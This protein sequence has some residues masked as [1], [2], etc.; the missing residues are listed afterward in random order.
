MAF[1][2]KGDSLRSPEFHK[3]KQKEKWLKISAVSV[4][5]VLLIMTPILLSRLNRFLVSNIEI[6]GN[7]VTQPEEIE[8]LIASDLDGNY[9]LIF[10]KSNALLYPKR[11][12]LKDI[13]ENIPRIKTVDATLSGPKTLVIKVTEREPSGLYC[14]NSEVSENGCYFIDSQGFIFSRAASFTGDVYFIY[15][16][17]PPL[18]DPLGKSYLPTED[19]QKIPQFIKSLKEIGVNPHSLISTENE[20]HLILPGGG[21][22]IFNKKDKLE[23]IK[24]NLE[25]FLNDPE[26]MHAPDFLENVSYIDMRFG[27]KVFYKLKT[28]E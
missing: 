19:F 20:Y 18:E 7:S 21:K 4:F 17:D 8:K 1:F 5:V 22:I 15:S 24:S 10:P 13:Q 28:A 2:S 12:I 6:Q 3:K 25:S 14:A 23:S 26:N 11:K 9:L 16:S 27:N